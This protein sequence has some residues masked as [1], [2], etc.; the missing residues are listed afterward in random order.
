[1]GGAGAFGHQE[2]PG[3]SFAWILAFILA[4]LKCGLNVVWSDFAHQNTFALLEYCCW[5]KFCLKN[6]SAR[7]QG[8][9]ISFSREQ[10]Y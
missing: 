8:P 4:A 6:I 10:D 2:E 7:Q 5:C 3:L 9:G 1:M